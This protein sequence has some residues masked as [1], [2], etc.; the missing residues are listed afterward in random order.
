M[1]NDVLLFF[2]F[3]FAGLFILTVLAGIYAGVNYQ[4]LFGV[5]RNI[6]S[7]T[8]S[9]RAYSLVQ[10]FTVWAHAVVLTAAF[11]LALK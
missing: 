1:Q 11:A 2:R 8:G 9:S 6:P 5:D 10:I 4:K 3:V 7:E